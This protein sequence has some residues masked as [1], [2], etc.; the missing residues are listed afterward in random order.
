MAAARET[1]FRQDTEIAV[2]MGPRSIGDGGGALGL[3]Y[4]QGLGYGVAAPAGGQDPCGG[5][6]TSPPRVVGNG[7]GE[8]CSG[9]DSSS[10]SPVPA[11][12]FVCEPVGT[13][14]SLK[15]NVGGQ[16][17]TVEFLVPVRGRV[18]LNL[19]LVPVRPVGGRAVLEF[20]RPLQVTVAD[21]H[22]AVAATGGSEVGVAE[23]VGLTES[24]PA[25][26][27]PDRVEGN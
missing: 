8:Y 22:A 10:C 19:D 18:V 16:V 14:Y 26:F 27:Y 25:A 5:N 9:G 17:L 4:Y 1:R 7:A 2:A 21:V 3:V 13:R 11:S 20:P 24:T 6:L 12:Y 15:K 23:T